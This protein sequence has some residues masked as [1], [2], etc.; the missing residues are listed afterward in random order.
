MS[1]LL[2]LGALMQTACS[3]PDPMSEFVRTTDALPPGEQPPGWANVKRLMSRRA[4][5]VG[6]IAADFT[7]A[8]PDG[9][10]WITRST[11]AAG[12]PLVLIFGSFT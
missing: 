12:R 4:P 7:L 11:F 2:L 6:E 1:L 5:A 9:T 10:R 3:K 8:T